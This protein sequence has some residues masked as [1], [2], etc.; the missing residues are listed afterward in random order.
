MPYILWS[1]AVAAAR[2][3]AMAL[4]PVNNTF[5]VSACSFIC[6]PL[7]QV[8]C[9]WS[10]LGE[11]MGSL[12]NIHLLINNSYNRWHHDARRRI[13][14]SCRPTATTGY[15]LVACASHLGRG[16]AAAATATAPQGIPTNNRVNRQREQPQRP[17]LMC[18]CF[19]LLLYK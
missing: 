15:A 12:E 14:A 13:I 4:Q 8:R 9:K 2:A 5:P 16:G 17:K 19:L 10:T 11:R 6:A 3:M 18:C 7:L 1:S